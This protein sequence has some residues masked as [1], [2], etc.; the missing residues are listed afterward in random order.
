MQWVIMRISQF[1]ES[2]VLVE[3]DQIAVGYINALEETFPDSKIRLGLK[4]VLIEF[5][6]A[7]AWVDKVTALFPQL[8]L[9]EQ[10][11]GEIFVIPTKYDG[12]DLANLA[13]SLKV[14]E[15]EIISKHL[16]T[17]WLVQ[18]IGFAPGFPYLL[19]E[20]NRGFFDQITRLPSPRK[21]VPAGS[22]AVAAGMSC[23]YPQSSPGGWQLIGKTEVVLFDAALETPSL[24]SV[25]DRVRFEAID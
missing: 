16:E 12:A 1:G 18:L 17:N 23:I 20:T 9:K 25:G 3:L 4:S 7:G 22:V 2:A 6:Q 21:L 10:P 5:S 15:Q 13:K 14:T 24:L 8:E 11:V 19:P